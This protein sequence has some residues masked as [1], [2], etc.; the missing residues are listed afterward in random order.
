M[1][2]AAVWFRF[3]NPMNRT[4]NL[5]VEALLERIAALQAENHQLAERVLKL[6]EELALARLHRFAPRSEKTR[7]RILNEAEQIAD[8]DDAGDDA[9][10]GVVKQI[11]VEAPG[12]FRVSSA[13]HMLEQL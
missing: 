7:D 9:E 8:E 3:K 13:D 10:D 1:V 5:S 2:D 12:E 4:D 6:E 11:H